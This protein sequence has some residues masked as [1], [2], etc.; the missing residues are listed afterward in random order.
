MSLFRRNRKRHAVYLSFSSNRI[1]SDGGGLYAS[2]PL[3]QLG[4]WLNEHPD[5]DLVTVQEISS[6]PLEHVSNRIVTKFLVV[7]ET[8]Y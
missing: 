1:G 2:T 3:D 6:Q 4:Q 8:K 7:Y 5:I